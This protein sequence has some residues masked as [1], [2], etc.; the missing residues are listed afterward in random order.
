MKLLNL[1]IKRGQ[2][3]TTSNSSSSSD[4]SS[5]SWSAL[6]W[7]VFDLKRPCVTSQSR[8]S[9]KSADGSLSRYC[10]VTH[11]SFC[12]APLQVEHTYNFVHLRVDLLLHMRIRFVKDHVIDWLNS[13]KHYSTRARWG[14][15]V[16][17]CVRAAVVLLCKR[18]CFYCSFTVAVA[19]IVLIFKAHV[20][21]CPI[22]QSEVVLPLFSE[23]NA[24]F[25]VFNAAASSSL[26]RSF[27]DEIHFL[28][29]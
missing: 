13:C 21:F 10:D 18:N 12:T 11:G 22:S 28:G 27:S 19:F 15:C 25:Y 8:E 29:I 6:M 14:V 17:V 4:V 16:C 26:A 9:H 3:T 5:H 2:T 7:G 1:Y 24:L 23:C 20:M